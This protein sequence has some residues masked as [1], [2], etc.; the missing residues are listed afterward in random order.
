MNFQIQ[1]YNNFID[2]LSSS[3]L[4]P[5]ILIPTRISKTSTLIDNISNSTSLQEIE[6]VNVAS[7]FWDHLPQFICLKYFFSKISAVKS[8]ILKYDRRKFGSNKFIFDF[9]QTDWQQILCTEQSDVIFSMNQYLSKSH[10][11]L[12]IMHHLKSLTKKNW[13]FSPDHGLHKVYKIPLKRKIYT[14]NV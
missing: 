9:N 10:S 12:E 6:S 3:F 8:N 7:T 1:L 13:N 11:L 5:H 2:T 14:Q 4:L